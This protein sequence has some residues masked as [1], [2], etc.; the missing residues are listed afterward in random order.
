MCDA[1]VLPPNEV[2][3][4]CLTHWKTGL[5][6]AATRQFGF[7][8]PNC[9]D[10]EHFHPDLFPSI[11]RSRLARPEFHLKDDAWTLPT[12]TGMGV[13]LDEQVVEQCLVRP[14]TVIE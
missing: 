4:A 1:L 8:V 13:E 9:P 6:V 7:A 3:C 12:N 11:L 2:C 5:T 10:V 14:L